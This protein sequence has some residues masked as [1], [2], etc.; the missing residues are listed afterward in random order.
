MMKSPFTKSGSTILLLAVLFPIIQV[1]SGPASH[2]I[3]K[4]S[5]LFT[6]QSIV[7]W[8]APAPGRGFF[9]K[10]GLAIDADGAARANHPNDQLGL[11]SLAHA[12]HR[13]NWWAL[14][15]DNEKTSGTPVVQGP[16]DPA[17]GYYVSTTAL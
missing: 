3:C 11:D 12:G 8:S 1:A 16:A 5:K 4:K 10:S 14:V 13:G 7:A 17:P 6:A 15:T 2:T 9:Y